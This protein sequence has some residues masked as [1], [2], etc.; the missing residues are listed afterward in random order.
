V[1]RENELIDQIY[2]AALLPE[3]WLPVLDRLGDATNFDKTL[4]FVQNNSHVVG[5]LANEAATPIMQEFVAR[6]LMK[7]SV[8]DQLSLQQP[9]PEFGGDLDV[10]TQEQ[11]DADPVYQDFFIPRGVAWVVGSLIESPD[12]NMIH[13]SFNRAVE[14]GPV[15]QHEKDY[16]T[17]FRPHLAR[18]SL[19][20]ARLKLEQARTAVSALEFMG[21]PAAA[22]HNR[23]R[24]RLANTL[25]DKLVPTLAQD[26]ANRLGFVHLA[27]DVLLA[28]ALD[29]PAQ[30][31]SFPV[32]GRDESRYIAHLLPV[33]GQGRDV[34][35]A[36]D[37]LL[38]LV[39]VALEGQV[40][41]RILQG[42]FDLTP[43]EA[44]VARGLMVGSTVDAIS[45]ANGTSAETVRTQLKSV[46][47]KTGTTRQAELVALLSAAKRP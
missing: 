34:F 22:L 13:F 39:P 4:L 2:E 21:L 1:L 42:L 20:S 10:L 43:A 9:W 19:I 46:L 31:R 29:D 30:A 27:S 26:K 32:K 37:A 17:G 18:A 11:I 5:Y 15:T 12:G 3:Q 36:M 28:E 40:D 33:S 44:R 38:V 25:F 24:L 8:R 14:H 23:G 6:D 16:L 45:M 41:A 35:S 7:K 47:S